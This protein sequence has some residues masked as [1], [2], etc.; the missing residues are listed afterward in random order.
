MNA[1]RAPCFPAPARGPRWIRRR[2]LRVGLRVAS[3]IPLAVFVA[4]HELDVRWL[5]LVVVA[6]L[7]TA[8]LLPR[9]HLRVVVAAL[10]R[11]VVRR[12]RAAPSERD[13]PPPL[14]LRYK[15]D[16]PRRWDGDL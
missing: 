5:E 11:L 13:A 15:D 3:L 14:W 12:R 8:A 10:L 9:E 1:Y 16:R 6:L 2:A 7:P 4:A